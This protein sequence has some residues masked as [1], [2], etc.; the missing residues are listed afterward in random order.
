MAEKCERFVELM[1]RNPE[2]SQREAARQVG[3]SGGTP[4]PRAVELYEVALDLPDMDGAEEWIQRR[5]TEAREAMREAQTKL[6]ALT[7]KRRVM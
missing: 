4:S 5:L 6:R 2:M 7:I 3:Y 1:L